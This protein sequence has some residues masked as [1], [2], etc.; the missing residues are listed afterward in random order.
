M[1]ASPL[2]VLGPTA[3][4]KSALAFALAQRIG[5]AQII[6]ADAK[7]VYRGM[8]IG[9]AKPS[10]EEQAAV[11]HHL[12]DVVDPADD[13]ALGQ[14]QVL[15]AEAIEAI[16]RAGDLPII[17]GGTGLYVQA[18][19]DDF[20]TPDRFPDVAEGL[21]RNPDSLA[22]YAQLAELDPQA[23]TKM[24]PNNRRR[25]IRALEVTLGSGKPFSSFGP[26]VDAFPATRFTLIGLEIE[27][28]VMD[29]RINDRFD[30][31][32]AAGFLAEVASLPQPLSRTAAASLGYRELLAHLAGR[33][34]ET[35]A[36]ELAKSRTRRFARRQQRWF[37]RDPRIYWLEATA[38]DLIEQALAL[39][40]PTFRGRLE[41]R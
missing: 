22:L 20:T 36:I 9:T 40:D 25:I 8:D 5:T 41:S 15:V 1:S 3:S 26:G 33:T 34:S 24:E 18:I 28:T 30:A 29:Q 37:R 13:F 31:H 39:V 38:P 32:M 27:R 12:V 35:E 14:F 6:S 7:A 17:V 4:G 10:V 16:E 11:P 19:V 2:V 23:A 21:E